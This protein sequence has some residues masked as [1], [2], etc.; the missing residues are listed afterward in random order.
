M[1]F[2][3]E[4]EPQ[5]FDDLDSIAEFIR[6]NGSFAI[7]EKWFNGVIEDIASLD[8][9]PARCPVAPESE[10]LGQEVR[11]LLHGRRNRTYKIY[12][13]IEY[14]TPTRGIVRVFHVRHWAQRPLTNLQLE[15]LV[16]QGRSND[17]P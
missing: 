12:F 5:A 17:A 15:E 11:L 3:V 2:R 1:A 13:S 8:E 6:A 16:K 10:E 7:A 9:M 4:I 14:G